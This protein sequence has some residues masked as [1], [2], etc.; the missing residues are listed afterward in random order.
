MFREF[1]EF[2]V[3]PSVFILPYSSFMLI[4]K[5]LFTDTKHSPPPPVVPQQYLCKYLLFCE[6]LRF[7]R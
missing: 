3:T 4:P 2:R 7:R 6:N 1:I 5:G